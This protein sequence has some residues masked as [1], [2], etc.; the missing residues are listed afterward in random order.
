M[1]RGWIGLDMVLALLALA[2][3]GNDKPPR[4]APDASHGPASSAPGKAVETAAARHPVTVPDAANGVEADGVDGEVQEPPLPARPIPKVG[5][6]V[7]SDRAPLKGGWTYTGG[8]SCASRID[9]CSA[10]QY[11]QLEPGD[12][13]IG[14]S[15]YVITKPTERDA[16]GGISKGRVTHVFY[17]RLNALESIFCSIGGRHAVVAFA[18]ENWRNGTAYVTDGKTLQVTKWRD[19]APPGCLPPDES[20]EPEE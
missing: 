12:S 2:G 1:A 13:N 16:S 18:D 11:D 19:K 9:D 14:H 6:I 15:L 7:P 17:A 20:D 4:P 5:D 3:C 8:G 10:D